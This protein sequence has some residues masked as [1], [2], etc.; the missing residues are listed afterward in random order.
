[1]TDFAVEK[2]VG[3]IL[4]AMGHETDSQMWARLQE[5]Y[6]EMSDG[7]LLEMAASPEDLTDVAQQVLRGE[8]ASRKLK[9][10][11]QQA[12]PERRWASDA[13]GQSSMAAQP[14]PAV[15]LGSAPTLD[16]A[17]ADD[18]SVGKDESLLGL[19]YD[20]IE[21]GR[22]CEFLEAAGVP[23]RI[24][25]VS[26]PKSG[27]GMYDSPPVALNVI[28][29]K[30]DRERAMAVL[31]KEMGL[32]PLQE[33]ADPD[34]AVDDGTVSQVGYFGSRADADAVASALDDAG[35]WHR[36]VA[37][38]E[39]SAEAEDAWVVEVREVDLMRA[40]DVVEKAFG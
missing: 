28:V 1:L 3:G 19:F 15:I 24:E 25:D 31:R 10:E 30:S 23:F 40:G 18:S 38:E 11:P 21:V 12:R 20:A 4:G 39:G 32:F 8:M 16:A 6:R 37:N 9:I 26:K 5:R 22:M 14:V 29:A 13:F 7:E 36:L 2:W 34:A 33:V 27:L 35:I 17:P